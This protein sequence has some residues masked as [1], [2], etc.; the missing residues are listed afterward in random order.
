MTTLRLPEQLLR[1]VEEL[2]GAGDENLSRFIEAALRET[3]ARRRSRD[4]EPAPLQ[5]APVGS[6]E[7]LPSVDLSRWAQFLESQA[8]APRHRHLHLS[9]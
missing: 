5:V 1:E 2:A 3:V 6:G 8:A 4:V 9:A 7:V